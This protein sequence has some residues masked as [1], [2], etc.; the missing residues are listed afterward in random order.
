MS[1]IIDDSG[2]YDAKTVKQLMTRADFRASLDTRS[3]SSWT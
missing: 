1:Q 3:S 2:F